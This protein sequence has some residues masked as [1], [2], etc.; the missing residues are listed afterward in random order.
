[1]N[2]EVMTDLWSAIADKAEPGSHIIFRTAS[3]GSPIETNLPE[4]L[5]S[6]F[7]Y[8]EA[9]SKEL[10]KQDRASIYGGFHL[11]ILKS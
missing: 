9:W 5:R 7:E 6:R 8:E 10:F 2:A 3:A 1:M 4:D 11:Y